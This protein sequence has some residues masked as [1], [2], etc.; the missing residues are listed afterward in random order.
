MAAPG[1]VAMVRCG[2]VICWRL[3]WAAGLGLLSG[4][5]R[6]NANP[7]DDFVIR[8]GQTWCVISSAIE[9]DTHVTVYAPEIANWDAHKVFVTK[10]WVDAEWV[11]PGPAVNRAGIEHP[12]T[13][14]VFRH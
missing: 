11:L 1:D 5:S 7:N 3:L 8:P 9:G 6:G 4:F 12:I 10:H 2:R 13:T 14:H